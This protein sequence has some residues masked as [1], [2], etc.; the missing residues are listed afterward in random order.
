MSDFE[1]AKRVK[2]DGI[3]FFRQLICKNRR[4]NPGAG[5]SEREGAVCIEYFIYSEQRI[6]GA[7]A[8]LYTVD[9][10]IPV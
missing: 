10:A 9:C 4:V 3:S 5:A 2:I 6:Y 7:C 1:S 8:G